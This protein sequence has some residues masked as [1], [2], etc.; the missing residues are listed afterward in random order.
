MARLL[1]F[2]SV[3]NVVMYGFLA[4]DSPC[5]CSRRAPESMKEISKTERSH[6]YHSGRT[7]SEGQSLDKCPTSPQ[8]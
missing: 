7:W 1:D 8:L 5:I 4:W 2:E 6:E 3:L